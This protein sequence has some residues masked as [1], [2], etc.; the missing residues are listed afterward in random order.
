MST[1]KRKSKKPRM[2]GVVTMM[3]DELIETID[4]YRIEKR[5]WSRARAIRSLISTGLRKEGVGDGRTYK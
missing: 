4:L 5:I 1:A 2:T 3:P